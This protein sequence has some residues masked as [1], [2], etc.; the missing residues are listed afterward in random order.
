MVH[1]VIPADVQSPWEEQAVST[2]KR[3]A[4]FSKYKFES[5]L[6]Q[7]YF[8]DTPEMWSKFGWD[9]EATSKNVMHV[10]DFREWAAL[11]IENYR[12]FRQTLHLNLQGECAVIGHFWKPLV[13]HA[14]SGELYLM[15]LI[16]PEDGKSNVCWN[17]G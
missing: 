14:V 9:T 4:H 2:S 12:T 1:C 5:Y 7:W 6:D 13:E 15:L 3:L 11:N 16:H 17:V 8:I 10:I